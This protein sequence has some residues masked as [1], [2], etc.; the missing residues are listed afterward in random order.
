M[1]TDALRS[2]K[3]SKTSRSPATFAQTKRPNS[4][5]AAAI[6][7]LIEQRNT[8]FIELSRH[9]FPRQPVPFIE[10]VALLCGQRTRQYFLKS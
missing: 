2:R 1:F 4:R 9:V 8:G 3:I 5:N 7:G 10:A 6:V